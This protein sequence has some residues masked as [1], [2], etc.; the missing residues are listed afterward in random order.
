[1]W[2]RDLLHF[3]ILIVRNN[4][5]LSEDFMDKSLDMY[6][7]LLESFGDVISILKMETERYVVCLRPLCEFLT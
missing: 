7:V 4:V 6:H 5:Y 2:G 3:A 1:M